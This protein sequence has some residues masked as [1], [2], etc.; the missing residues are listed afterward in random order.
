[1]GAAAAAV[2]AIV[3]GVLVI[4]PFDSSDNDEIAAVVD[5]PDAITIACRNA[6]GGLTGSISIVYSQRENAVVVQG[7]DLATPPED[8]V[9]QLWAIRD[10]TAQNAGV[11]FRPDDGDVELYV[12]LRPRQRRGMG[13]DR[14]R[15][16]QSDPDRADPRHHRLISAV[17]P[18]ECLRPSE[19][20]TSIFPGV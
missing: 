15:R 13:G 11:S 1:M 17:A 3:A 4:S 5:D 19:C 2:V 10:E 12:R 9:Y 18:S 6:D 20:W 16:Q 8:G 7:Q 14:A